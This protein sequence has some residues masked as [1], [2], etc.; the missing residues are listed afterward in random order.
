VCISLALTGISYGL[1]EATT[2]SPLVVALALAAGLIMLGLFILVESRV[3]DPMLPL[4]VFSSRQFSAANGVTFVVYAALSG[5][6][7]LVPVVLQEVRGYSPLQAGISLLPVTVIMLLLSARSGALAAKIGPRLQMTVGPL[8]IAA[9]LVLFV[10]LPGGGS[11]YTAVLPAVLV[12][13]FGLAINVAPLTATALA[14]APAEH[15]G[16]ASAVNND[17]A[18]AAGLIAVAVLPVLA[19]ITGNSYLHSAMLA[20]GFRIAALISAGF[21][22]A[23]GVLAAL[24]IRNPSPE[25]CADA[26][27]TEVSCGLE[28]PPLRGRTRERLPDIVADHG[29]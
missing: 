4:S 19:G 27:P 25:A 11:Y 7:F 9:G 24:T 29:A 3:T 13:G 17:V 14:A 2:A 15:A 12:F 16:I 26:S 5:V 18:R 22:A 8:V 1:I 21:C 20:H 10:R 23:G 28:A 6:L